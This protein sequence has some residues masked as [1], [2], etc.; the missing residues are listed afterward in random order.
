MNRHEMQEEISFKVPSLLEQWRDQWA[1]AEKLRKKFIGDFSIEKTKN[2]TLDDYVIGK[3]RE[4][5]SF[6]YRIERELDFLGRILGAPAAKFGIWYGK[7][8]SDR[9]QKYRYVKK[10]GNTHQEAFQNVRKEIVKLL[11]SANDNDWEMLLKNKLSPMFKG[12]ILFVYYPDRFLNVFSSD[13]L[14]NFIT[15]LNLVSL[16]TKELDMQKAI[17]EY[18]ETWPELLEHKM[19]LWSALLYDICGH[20]S[21]DKENRT[22]PFQNVVKKAVFIDQLPI[23]STDIAGGRTPAS[24]RKKPD[25]EKR[26]RQNKKIGDRGEVLVFEREK[27]RLTESGRLDLSRS[28]KHVSQTDDRAGYDILSFDEDGS[29]R[30]IEV[31]ST[32]S[33]TLD[34]GFYL[35]ANELEKTSQL[36]NYHIYFVFSALS[37][38]PKI[39]RHKNPNFDEGEPLH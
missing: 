22:P 5:R 7:K 14:M 27:I 25:Y 20:P 13:H 30:P 17:V 9:E 31:K 6:C 12:K 15:E 28:V 29:E 1:E 8:G 11:E 3:G 33:S 23:G 26:S 34:R 39:Y 32:T 37:E 2:L 19:Y 24:G 35:T 38:A 18:R 21:K 10:F 16:S 36:S 4:N